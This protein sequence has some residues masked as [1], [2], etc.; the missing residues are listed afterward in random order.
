MPPAHRLTPCGLP[1]T[2]LDT[3]SAHARYVRLYVGSDNGQVPFTELKVWAVLPVAPPPAPPS[4]PVCGDGTPPPAKACARLYANTW[5]QGASS[6]QGCMHKTR[7][8]VDEACRLSPRCGGYTFKA[9]ALPADAGQ[10]CLLPPMD[11]AAVSGWGTGPFDYYACGLPELVPSSAVTCSFGS[12][13]GGSPGWPGP[14]GLSVA[15]ATCGQPA[16]V[17]LDLRW[18]RVLSHVRVFTPDSDFCGSR[19]EFSETGLFAGEEQVR[20]ATLC[21]PLFQPPASTFATAFEHPLPPF[22]SPGDPLQ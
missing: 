12:C 15:G 20:C 11:Y 3:H 9:G 18:P 1:G 13:A 19:L 16:W 7:A 4:E 17:Q 2:L 21:Q 14:L 8:E 5:P 10:G 6:L 22:S